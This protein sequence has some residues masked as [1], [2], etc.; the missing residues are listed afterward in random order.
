MHEE[1]GN[2][3]PDPLASHVGSMPVNTVRARA[4]ACTNVCAGQN[5]GTATDCFARNSRINAFKAFRGCVPGLLPISS[6]P[7]LRSIRSASLPSRFRTPVFR[8]ASSPRGSCLMRGDR[9]DRSI[10]LRFFLRF[11]LRK[12]EILN[13]GFWAFFLFFFGFRFVSFMCRIS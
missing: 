2:L 7:R 13:R 12:I 1:P 10:P 8:F 5:R 6:I 3:S 9:I 4:F 11:F